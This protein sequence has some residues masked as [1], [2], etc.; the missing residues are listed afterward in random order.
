MIA[1]PDESM[2]EMRRITAD[3]GIPLIVDEVQTG[4]GRTG[5]MWAIEHSG[6][7]PDVLLPSR[8]SVAIC[9]SPSRCTPTSSTFGRPALAGEGVRV[10]K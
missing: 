6:V 2:R 7:S 4:V 3:R 5:A 1:A 10:W 9:R 8:R